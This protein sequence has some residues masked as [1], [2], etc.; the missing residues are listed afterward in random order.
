MDASTKILLVAMPWANPEVPSIQLGVLKTYLTDRGIDAEA[1]HW[2]LE[3]GLD[4]GFDA[5]ARLS[6]SEVS[7][8]ETLY[9][10]LLFPEM[11]EGLLSHRAMM[12]RARKIEKS[13]KNST[14]EPKVTFRWE[15]SFFRDFENL[16]R[17]ILDRYR[18]EDYMLVGFTLNYGQTVA[19]LYMA[20]EIKKR[21]P[22]CKIIFGGA[23][24]SG[25][26]GASLVENFSQ[27]D[28]ACNG[29]GELLLH[30]LSEALLKGETEEAICG[31]GGLTCRRAGGE[32]IANH[33]QQLESLDQLEIPDY[34]EYFE[35][36]RTRGIDPQAIIRELP[37][38]A[39]RGCPFSCNFCGLN[40]QWENFR[41]RSPEKVSEDIRKLSEKYHV[42]GFRFMDNI[43]PKDSEKIFE[44]I[45]R[46][47]RN[48][49]FFYEIRAQTPPRVL[50]LMKT[51]GAVTLQCGVE[52][53][54]TPLLRKF[55]KKSKFINNLQAMKLCEELGIDAGNNLITRFPFST[56]EDVAETL[57]NM[58]FCLAYQPANIS[59]YSLGVGS[60][61]Y[62]N[63]RERGLKKIRNASIY[64]LI[65]P[66]SLF[67]RLHLIA[68]DFTAR[69]PKADW[70]PVTEALARWRKSYEGGKR[71]LLGGRKYLLSYSDGGTFLQIEDYRGRDDGASTQYLL[72]EIQREVYLF[73]DEIR[74]W[75]AFR[76]V[77]D[78]EEGELSDLL[79]YFVD[80]KLM[81]EEDG[82]YLSLA[83][84][85]DV[86]SKS[87]ESSGRLLRPVPTNIA[88]SA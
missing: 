32:V 14:D 26:L 3:I 28:Y 65:Y 57:R 81:Y 40:L 83:M 74:P 45:T 76:E 18:W 52:A 71:R 9:S 30:R 27:L 44:K 20:R 2:Y 36:L 7:A 42:L 41:S 33:P 73:A 39:S 72:D 87:E 79:R 67:E 38:E 80:H 68:K 78:L 34:D 47:G 5:Y 16:H 31:I 15:D 49:R 17:S 29:E 61:D 77:F 63:A 58:E 55:N 84:N 46:Q 8:S 24:A 86:R 51:A 6:T 60:P 25:E 62:R 35:A 1:A 19:S 23:E 70:K 48:Y 43:L 54:S 75:N 56:Q 21:N 11:R 66:E 13:L 10:Y 22:L 82:H 85:S 50:R 59:V 88:A 12:S 69:G 4:M 64:R 53:F 37:I